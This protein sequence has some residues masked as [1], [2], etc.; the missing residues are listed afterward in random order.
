MLMAG[1]NAAL[2]GGQVAPIKRLPTSPISILAL[3][4]M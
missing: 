4:G 3:S 2:A 1:D